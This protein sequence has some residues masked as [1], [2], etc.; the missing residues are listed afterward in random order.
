VAVY[1]TDWTNLQTTVASTG[2]G[3]IGNAGKARIRGFEFGGVLK[4]V[5]S[6]TLRTA[7]TLQK[8]ELTEANPGLS[9]RAGE[10]LPNSPNFALSVN[11]KY[12]FSMA[13]D[14]S[15]ASLSVGY[16][17]DRTNSFDANAG[18]VNLHQPAYT[19]VDFNLGT[20]FGGFDLGFYVRN[21]TDERA[22]LGLYSPFIQVGGPAQVT[23]AR[24]RT[25]GITASKAC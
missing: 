16:T 8:A 6:L 3:Y 22:Q 2:A 21:L 19:L 1:Q 4:P 24:P 14:P 7:F 9:G 23:Y 5:T 15:F 12:D 25:I 20:N 10:R 17:G 13:G 18:Y 11:G